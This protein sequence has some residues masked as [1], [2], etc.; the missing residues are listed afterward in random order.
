MAEVWEVRKYWQRH[1]QDGEF[2]RLERE[3]WEEEEADHEANGGA[4]V[5]GAE[6]EHSIPSTHYV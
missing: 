1:L 6:D 2:A 5:T 3:H 4:Q